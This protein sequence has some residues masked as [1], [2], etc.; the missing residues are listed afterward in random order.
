MQ[1]PQIFRRLYPAGHETS[2]F[3]INF[4]KFFST[5]K[6]D[7]HAFSCLTG[8]GGGNKDR[9]L[10]EKVSAITLE[11]GKMTNARRT[12]AIPQVRL[13][14]PSSAREGKGLVIHSSPDPSLLLRKWVRLARLCLYVV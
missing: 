14:G 6:V 4:K 3:G 7:F 8:G 13:Y 10:L 1:K 5:S 2:I 9:V 12:S 11:H